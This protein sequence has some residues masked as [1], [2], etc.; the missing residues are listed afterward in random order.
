MSDIAIRWDTAAGDLLVEADDLAVDD[1]LETAVIL[2]LFCDR[3]AE[4]GDQLPSATDDLRGWWGDAVPDVDADRIG[5]RLWLLSRST[6]SEAVVARAEEYAREAL[7]WLLE[8]KVAEAVDVTAEVVRYGVLGLAVSI[9]RP[10]KDAVSYR[11]NYNWAAQ[12]AR[13]A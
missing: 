3:R 13:G 7:A 11:Y 6:L 12:E 5:S 8:D 2:S 9:T 1:G 10:G 4:P